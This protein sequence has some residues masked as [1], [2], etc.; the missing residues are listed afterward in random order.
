MKEELSAGII[1]YKCVEDKYLYLL[2]HYPQ[3]HWGFPKGHVE[4]GETALEA[5]RRELKEETS[6]EAKNIHPEFEEKIDYY[7]TWEGEKRYKEVV[8]FAG[9]V[10]EAKVKISHEHQDFCWL[11]ADETAEK[12]TYEDEK[13]LF[14]KW[15]GRFSG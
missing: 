14:Q 5:A 4:A 1:S 11:E 13:E 6:L 10:E 15:R 7:Y 8:F 9:E 2:L 12:I 3:G